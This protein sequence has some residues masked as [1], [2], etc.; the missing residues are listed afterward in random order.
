MHLL[1]Q[2]RKNDVV[3]VQTF[4]GTREFFLEMYKVKSKVNLF[5][6]LSLSY[7]F[8]PCHQRVYGGI[9]DLLIFVK[10]YKLDL[11][12]Y[13]LMYNHIHTHIY[14]SLSLTK[15]HSTSIQSPQ[16]LEVE[17]LKSFSDDFNFCKKIF[18]Y[19]INSRNVIIVKVL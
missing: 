13:M 17:T 18:W 15:T 4:K 14:V 9:Y 10:R 8:L 6:S 11:Y 12:V 3:L 19:F 5:L 1:I 2:T 7:S 16:C